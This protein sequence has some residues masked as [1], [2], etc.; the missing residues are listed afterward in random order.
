M[1]THH[2]IKITDIGKFQGYKIGERMTGRFSL[3][4]FK[5]LPEPVKKIPGM[6]SKAVYKK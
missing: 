1:G 6:K 5:T 2:A 3:Q 4:I